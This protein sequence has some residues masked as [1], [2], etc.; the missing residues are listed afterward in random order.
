MKRSRAAQDDWYVSP[1]GA[2]AS[3]ME[4]PP[5]K[6]TRLEK[7]KLGKA[8]H[9]IQHPTRIFVVGRSQM[10]KTTLAVQV[11][12]ERFSNMDRFIALCPSFHS[13]ETFDPIRH[14]FKKEDVYENPKPSTFKKIVDDIKAFNEFAR[15]KG[16]RKPRTFILIDDMAGTNVIH[17]SGKGA[18]AHFSIQVTHAGCSTMVISQDP[19][20]VDPNFRK[21]CENFIIFPSEAKYDMK[22]LEES[23]NSRVFS[24]HHDFTD[25]VYQAWTAGKGN[26]EIG[27]HFL[28]ISSQP[29]SLS[30]FFSDFDNQVESK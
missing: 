5:F 12:K 24:Q 30:K 26:N 22:W 29:R 6:K 13:Q 15:A 21:N 18:F 28:F 2:K 9:L 23:F 3:S 27:K 19:I 7:R 4:L 17:G 1:F 11:I 16:E 25:I 10:G 8:A 20:R 14:L